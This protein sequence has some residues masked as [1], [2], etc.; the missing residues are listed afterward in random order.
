MKREYFDLKTFFLKTSLASTLDKIPLRIFDIYKSLSYEQ[1]A[2]N[3]IEFKSIDIGLGKISFGIL[4][5]D[6]S[7]EISKNLISRILKNYLNS[8]KNTSWIEQNKFLTD[9]LVSTLITSEDRNIKT[10]D[11]ILK[12]IE[13]TRANLQCKSCYF[14]SINDLHILK[15]EIGINKDGIFYHE[16]FNKKIFTIPAQITASTRENYICLD[17]ETDENLIPFNNGEVPIKNLSAFPIIHRE[18]VAGVFLIC[19]KLDPD[20]NKRDLQ[21]VERIMRFTSY[22]LGESSF[23]S[24][25]KKSEEIT[26]HLSKFLSK[27]IADKIKTDGLEGI[28]GVEKKI[29]VMFAIIQDFEYLTTHLPTKTLVQILNFFYEETHKII[30][31][32][33][34]TIDKIMTPAIMAVWNHPHSQEAPEKNALE[35]AVE[36]QL[37]VINT[38]APL[39]KNNGIK[40]FS[41]GIGINNGPAIAGN[42]GSKNF[43]DYTVIGDTINTAQRLE[44]RSGANEILLHENVYNEIFAQNKRVQDKKIEIKVKGKEKPITVFNYRFK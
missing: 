1:N 29:V 14:F 40:K 28:G 31:L 30:N 9:S 38:I 33:N 37:K 43:M 32:N 39:L 26:G 10:L 5:I 25:L 21:I 3:L 44:S 6:S 8:L 16:D 27:N 23:H 11:Q 22:I 36:I 17:T 4:E 35:C 18:E 19:D 15:P 42:L 41:I 13:I 20:Y 34:G 24:Q 2:E 7:Y 12:I